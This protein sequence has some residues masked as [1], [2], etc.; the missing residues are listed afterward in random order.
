MKLHSML[1]LFFKFVDLYQ[2]RPGWAKG[3]EVGSITSCTVAVSRRNYR[4]EISHVVK[5]TTDDPIIIVKPW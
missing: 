1:V 4:D 5:V 2:M 3:R